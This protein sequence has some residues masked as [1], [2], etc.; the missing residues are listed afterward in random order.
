LRGVS[1]QKEPVAR[2]GL[3]VQVLNAAAGRRAL[4]AAARLY[5]PLI[6]EL[7]PTPETAGSAEVLA[8]ALYAAGRP[9]TAEKW[10]ALAKTD[11]AGNKA[12]AGLWPL[13]RATRVGLDAG[14]PDA[15]TA[16]LAAVGNN[17]RRA[18]M[19]IAMLQAVGETI[20]ASALS[21]LVV[22][23]NTPPAVS[24][25]PV[26]RTLLRA[27]AEGGRKAETV[28]LA[29]AMVGETGLDVIDAD[30]LG[31]VVS[32]LRQVGLEREAR[33]LA[34]EAILANGG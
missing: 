4:P 11:P 17:E 7:S 1:A 24:P 26:L 31:Q 3:I 25:R 5:A 14:P 13:S 19:T 29:S 21:S 33:Q 16:W 22:D 28:L 30:A 2:A 20:P 23:V 9:E 12:A 10:L 18:V 34:V 6:G 8:H 27:A 15:L 32:A